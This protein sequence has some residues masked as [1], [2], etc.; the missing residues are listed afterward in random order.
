M[1]RSLYF[2]TAA[3]SVKG[4]LVRSETQT[5]PEQPP[6]FVLG[7]N[8]DLNL[9]LVDGA[10]AFDAISGAGGYTVRLGIGP[11]GG[12]PTGGTFYLK[13]GSQ[14]SGTITSGKRYR[15]EDFNAGDDFA[16]VGGENETGSIFTA[17]G[18][19]PTTWTNA[20]ELI[21]IT[22]DL[23]YNITAA[24][25]ETALDLLASITADG[26]I[27]VTGSSPVWLVTW[28]DN[29]VIV[30]LEAGVE[31]LTPDSVASISE[32]QAGSTVLQEKQQVRLARNPAAFQDSWGTIT[33]GWNARLDCNT[34]GFLQLLN[35]A[36]AVQTVLELE[37]TDSGGNRATFAQIPI[38]IRNEVID[39]QSMVP[40]PLAD[41]S[42]T[43]EVQNQFVQN[44]SSLTGLTGG[45]ATNLDGIATVSATV[46]WLVALDVSNVLSLYRLESG[47][48][49][50]SSPDII[51]PD[52][53]AATTNEK[54]WRRLSIE[55]AGAATYEAIATFSAAG[56]DSITMPS[57]S[58]SHSVIADA[59][60]GA[61]GYTRTQTVPIANRSAGDIVHYRC[62][63]AASANPTVEIRNA[64][65]GGT[66]LTTFT[67]D[68][69]GASVAVA[70]YV[71]TGS[72]W[73]ELDATYI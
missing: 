73:V 40:S 31:N 22:T 36:V 15:I 35:G 42:T 24:A 44:R 18:T 68:A 26:G 4:A 60:A 20:S 71:Y 48:D 37:V 13:Y 56:D 21:E 33:D 38:T 3:K 6:E 46:G 25:L 59:G 45:G 34:R 47:T 9:Y 72:A 62:T 12:A 29:A 10:G 53:Y 2:N 8:P 43:V 39:E 64:T 14:T 52:D 54:I 58:V 19:T 70:S 30:P 41:Y 23:A 11:S 63:L 55:L 28:E 17:S 69:G 67:G 5:T 66:L 65:S 27:N 32:I 57:A 7:D 50:E 51:R 61:G 49:A 16:N 1:A